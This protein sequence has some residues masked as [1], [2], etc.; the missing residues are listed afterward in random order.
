DAESEYD[1]GKRP[2]DRLERL[3]GLRRCLD[4]RRALG[5]Q[6]GGGRQDDRDRDH[7]RHRHA[8]H[9]VDPYAPKL[10]MMSAAVFLEWS[11]FRVYAL[12]FGPL[13][14]MPDEEIGRD[15]RPEPRHE[16]RQERAARNDLRNEEASKRL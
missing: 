6:R 15:R 3:G 9:R 1:F 10:M 13:R 16:R 4:I 11:F 8:D 2:C 12:L 7:V 14:R 5:M